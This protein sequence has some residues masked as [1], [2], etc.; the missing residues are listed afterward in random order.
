[1]SAITKTIFTE[2]IKYY[3]YKESLS[4]FC[5]DNVLETE[6]WLKCLHND[7]DNIILN[8]KPSSY[9]HKPFISSQTDVS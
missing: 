5:D 4:C 3:N 2:D 1:M 7:R 9:Y 6:L 8:A